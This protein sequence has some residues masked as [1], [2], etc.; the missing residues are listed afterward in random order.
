M[1]LLEFLSLPHRF[2]WSG[3]GGDDCTTFAATWIHR[4]WGFD[5]A[6]AYRGSYSSKEGADAILAQAGGLVPFAGKML[7][8]FGFQ[9]TDTPQNGDVGVVRSPVGGDFAE[10]S[11]IRFG[12]LWAVLSPRGASAKLLQHVAAWRYSP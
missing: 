9:N 6:A 3:V 7:K 8:P 11:A 4:K 5:P 2:R 1:E 10:V 12:P